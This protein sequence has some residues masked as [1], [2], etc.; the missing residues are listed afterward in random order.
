MQQEHAD[1]VAEEGRHNFEPIC[2]GVLQPCGV[3]QDGIHRGCGDFQVSGTDVGPVRR[4]LASG[5]PEF[6]E[7]AP[8][9]EMARGTYKNRAGGTPSVSNVLSG[10][11]AGGVTLWEVDLGFAGSNL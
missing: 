5:L 2:R 9:L 3:R 1:V 6:C 11:G 7:G 8:S 10:S 4:R